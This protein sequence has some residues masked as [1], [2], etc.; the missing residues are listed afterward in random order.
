MMTFGVCSI[1]NH[2]IINTE[3]RGKYCF[4]SLIKLIL[5]TLINEQKERAFFEKNLIKTRS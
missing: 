2:L 4:E 5:I 1:N 3:L